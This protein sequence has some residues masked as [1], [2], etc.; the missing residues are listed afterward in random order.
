[1]PIFPTIEKRYKKE[2]FHV[3]KLVL[4]D[5]D[6]LRPGVTLEDDGSGNITFTNAASLPSI[7]LTA[8]MSG[9]SS[10]QPVAIDLKAGGA[11]GA[12]GKKVAPIMGHLIDADTPATLTA[13]N[14]AGGVIG[15][16]GVSAANNS[17]YPCGALLAQVSDAVNDTS[18]HG[19]VSYIDGDGSVT[20]CGA[21]FK[22]MCNNSTA[23]SGADWGLDL[24]DATHDGYLAVD[25]TFYKKA[26]LRLVDDVVFLT[27]AGA[28][29]S[30]AS[31]TGDNVAGPGSGYID[32]TNG[33]WYIQIGAITSPDWKL[34]TRAA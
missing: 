34:V 24:Q 15:A 23:T 1:M 17:T 26:P 16:Y 9:S 6:T 11:V 2:V 30:G 25:R 31:G 32:I 8:T 3:R 33:N 19:V 13:K 12:E 14:I 5:P 27:G 22:V 28:P 20:K 4:V 7:S 10:Y 21:M 29:T 18:V